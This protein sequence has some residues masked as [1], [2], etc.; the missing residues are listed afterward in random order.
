MQEDD[1][2]VIFDNSSA[3]NNPATGRFS[4]TDYMNAIDEETNDN[5]HQNLIWG[6][7][8]F[9]P[10]CAKNMHNSTRL[11]RHLKYHQQANERKFQCNICGKYCTFKSQYDKHLLIHYKE[12]PTDSIF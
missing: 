2:D 8:Y 3:T 12:Q 11:Q 10:I 7:E 4:H 5:L 9:C 6:N 1:G